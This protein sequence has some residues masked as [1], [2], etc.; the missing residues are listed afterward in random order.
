[1]KEHYLESCYPEKIM[2]LNVSKVAEERIEEGV[3]LIADELKR[4]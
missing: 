4:A 1:M 3:A 2:K